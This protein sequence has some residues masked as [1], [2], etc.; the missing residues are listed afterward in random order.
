[1]DSSFYRVFMCPHSNQSHDDT[2]DVWVSRSAQTLSNG[3]EE[4]WVSLSPEY[5]CLSI[6]G[7]FWMGSSLLFNQPVLDMQSGSGLKTGPRS[8]TCYQGDCLSILVIIL[9]SFWWSKMTTILLGC[10]SCLL[11]ETLCSITISI[12]D[13]RSGPLAAMNFASHYDT[14]THLASDCPLIVSTGINER[15]HNTLESIFTCS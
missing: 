5:L 7:S 15:T 12:N 8:M 13:W 11:T 3:L 10:S 14:C 9:D 1:M 2:S 6:S 4:I